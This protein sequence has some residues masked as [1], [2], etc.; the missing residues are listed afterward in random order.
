M[1]TKEVIKTIGTVSLGIWLAP[2]YIKS[3]KILFNNSERAWKKSNKVQKTNIILMAYLSFF[4]FIPIQKY[5]YLK[6]I[7]SLN[8]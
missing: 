7:E 5:L 6:Y 2:K 3:L 1:E 8:K 4:A